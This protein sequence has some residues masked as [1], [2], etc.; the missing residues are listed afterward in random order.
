MDNNIKT[1]VQHYR[2]DDSV[3]PPKKGEVDYRLKRYLRSKD[4]SFTP[5]PYG[6]QTSVELV[7]GDTGVTLAVGHAH[8]S[9]KDQFNYKTGRKI[10]FGRAMKVLKEGR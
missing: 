6:G 10:A 7:D 1:Y 4:N 3:Q 5:S 9:R 2:Y 8:C